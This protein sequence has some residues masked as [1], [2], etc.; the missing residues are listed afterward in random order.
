MTKRLQNSTAGHVLLQRLIYLLLVLFFA[1][2]GS[3]KDGLE[4]RAG[5]L[6]REQQQ[7][8][9]SMHQ[10][11]L[12]DL[13]ID[14]S[15]LISDKPLDNINTATADLFADLQVGSK[16]RSH[17]GVL[18]VVDPFHQQ[19]RTEISYCLEPVFPD[20]FVGYIQRRQMVP[21]FA[22]NNL[23]QGIEA[24][25]ELFVA[26]ARKAAEGLP[27]DP[28]TE[29]GPGFLS[30]GGGALTGYGRDRVQPVAGDKSQV[31]AQASPAAALAAYRELLAAH[32]R[33]S[34]LEIYSPDS[35]AFFSRRT[36]TDGQ[37]DQALESLRAGE[38]EKI[39]I[40]EPRAVIRYPA[41]QRQQSP[42]FLIHGKEGWMFDF[43]TMNRVIRMN[44]RNQWHFNTLD[45]PYMFAFADLRFDSNGFPHQPDPA[46]AGNR[47]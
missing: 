27:F 44:H 2:C 13:D 45:H 37:L 33:R 15:L 46:A 3:S 41:P 4:D 1:G 39:I 38:P 28:E 25:I 14:F 23:G 16:S 8:I 9:L 43:M 12:R 30:G 5:L 36:L 17:S 40:Q 31:P 47:P 22:D 35:R 19:V 20:S 18:L 42:F 7:R 24:T 6:D 26:R 11:L 32:N 10:A 29:I 34:D 21:F